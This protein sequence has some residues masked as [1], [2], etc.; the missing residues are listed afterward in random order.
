MVLHDQIHYVTG[1]RD[2]LSVALM[3]A[4]VPMSMRSADVTL[5]QPI[6]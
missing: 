5:S 3:L 4:P 1:H 2:V 6:A